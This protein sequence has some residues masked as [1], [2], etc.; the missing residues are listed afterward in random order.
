MV[1]VRSHATTH[2]LKIRCPNVRLRTLERCHV[3]EHFSN[4][5]LPSEDAAPRKRLS[6]TRPAQTQVG[7]SPSALTGTDLPP[8]ITI[9][10]TALLLRTTR[11]GIYAMVE[12]RQLP[13]IV[14]IGRRVLIRAADLVDWLRQK[15]LTP[16]SER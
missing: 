14:R 1:I 6:V 15:S 16:S 13:G 12:R 8:L 10:E 9:G 3:S 5:L 11:K 2:Q 7:S 4:R